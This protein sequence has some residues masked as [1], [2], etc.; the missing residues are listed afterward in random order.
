MRVHLGFAL[1]FRDG[2][3]AIACMLELMVVD[4][5]FLFDAQLMTHGVRENW[6]LPVRS[7][8]DVAAALR[9][10]VALAGRPPAE[11]TLH[12]MTLSTIAPPPNKW[13]VRGCQIY[14]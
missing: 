7:R 6:R 11:F 8:Y 1:T 13:L 12:S 14:S 9:Q 2:G 4:Q 10:V 5:L 3:E